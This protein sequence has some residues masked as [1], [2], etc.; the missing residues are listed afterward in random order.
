MDS[1][2][3]KHGPGFAAGLPGD[4]RPRDGTDRRPRDGTE[5]PPRDGTYHASRDGT[6]R[7]PRDGSILPA[8]KQLKR[9]PFDPVQESGWKRNVLQKATF[10]PLNFE[11][12]NLEL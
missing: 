5:H 11:L 7:R 1:T 4:I 6:F 10:E 3:N 9:S 8:R 2:N 12:L